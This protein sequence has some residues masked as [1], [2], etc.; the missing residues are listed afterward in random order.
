MGLLLEIIRSARLRGDLVKDDDKKSELKLEVGKTYRSRDGRKV[1]IIKK[2]D[3]SWPFRGNDGSGDLTEISFTLE[4]RFSYN[5][6]QDTANDLVE[7]WVDVP[8]PPMP[9]PKFNFRVGQVYRQRSGETTTI[10]FPREEHDPEWIAAYISNGQWVTTTGH[11]TIKGKEE[12]AHD[13]MELISDVPLS[14]EVGKFYKTR[15]GNIVHID[16]ER[17][18]HGY[19]HGQPIVFHGHYVATPLVNY[20][21]DKDG[22]FSP[23]SHENSS[24]LVEEVADSSDIMG[25][26]DYRPP[27]VIYKKE[28]EEYPFGGWKR[29]MVG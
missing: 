23:C 27:R 25:I 10:R 17:P 9:R 13:L 15:S 7:E 24:A 22:A 8:A 3:G 28:R 1:K 6:A 29:V 19:S 16:R 4:G 12:H 18:N 2:L 14:V 5:T 20:D 26:I 21:W 11:T